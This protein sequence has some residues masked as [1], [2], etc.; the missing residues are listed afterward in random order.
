MKLTKSLLSLVLALVCVFMLFGCGLSQSDADKINEKA[1]A[2]EHFTYA[3]IVEKYGEPTINATLEVLGSRNGVITYIEGV[4]KEEYDEKGEEAFKDAKTLIVTI[5]NNKAT[6]AV[7]AEN[8]EEA[9]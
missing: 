2:D 5:V 7:F 9:E 4:T 6:K 8:T 3:E 1:E